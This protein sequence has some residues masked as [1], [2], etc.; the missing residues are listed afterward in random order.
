M[1]DIYYSLI[2]SFIP[3]LKEASIL[4]IHLPIKI[5]VNPQIKFFITSISLN[6]WDGLCIASNKPKICS[7]SFSID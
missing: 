5:R 1:I 6:P 4:S 2:R 3:G 7:H